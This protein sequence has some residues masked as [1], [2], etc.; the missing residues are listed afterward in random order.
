MAV[1]LPLIISQHVTVLQG[2]HGLNLHQI[3]YISRRLLHFTSSALFDCHTDAMKI[4]DPKG[5]QVFE[6]GWDEQTCN[7]NNGEVAPPARRGLSGIF[8]RFLLHN[9]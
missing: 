2:V 8:L 1:P 5:L 6:L 9:T 3:C 4:A 7:A